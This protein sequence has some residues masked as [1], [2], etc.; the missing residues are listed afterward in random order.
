MVLKMMRTW[1]LVAFLAV[2][3][4]RGE[5]AREGGDRDPRGD[6]RA[7]IVSPQSILLAVGSSVSLATYVVGT[8]GRT[9]SGRSVTWASTDTSIASVDG[10]GTVRGLAV[11]EGVRVIATSEGHAGHAVVRVAPL[12]RDT[13]VASIKIAPP[14]ATLILGSAGQLAARAFNAQGFEIPGKQPRWTS[15]DS[16]AA[17]IDDRGLVRAVKVGGPVAITVTIDGASSSAS[18]IIVPRPSG[19]SIVVDAS[20]T[21]QVMTGWES[22]SGLGQQDCDTVGYRRYSE[23]VFDRAVHEVGINRLRLPLRS[24]M[25]NPVDYFDQF[26]AGR[27]T[28]DQWKP[29]WFRPV[30]DDADPQQLNPGGMQW[31]WFDSNVDDV[32]LPLQKR[33]RSR[34]ESL[35]VNLAYTD[36]PGPGAT[37]LHRD[38][39][40][41]YAEIVLATFQHLRQ[42]YGLTPDSFELMIEPDGAQWTAQQIGASAVAVQRR[43]AKH[44]FRPQYV[45]PSGKNPA[46][47]MEYFDAMMRVPGAGSVLQ[48]VSYHRY[49]IEPGTLS[50]LAKGAEARGMRTAMLEHIGS[51]YEDLHEDLIVGNASAWQQFGM[52]GCG[53]RDVGATYFPVYGA[54]VGQTNPVVTTGSRTRFLREYFLYVRL[55]AVR[56]RATTGNADFSPVAFRNVDGKHVV[57]VKATR[58]GRFIIR[59]LA[60]GT[61]GI[62]YTTANEYAKWL[63]DIVVTAG[64][65]ATAEIPLA[66]A[67]VI[68][69]R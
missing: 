35:W 49:G 7:V 2:L 23:Q 12:A 28:Y 3:G 63:P 45:G 6:G 26:Q 33:L 43:L 61:Y 42:K 40:E 4:C 9:E 25:E 10:S 68:H 55:G 8:D 38:A 32:L 22:L 1:P 14:L 17:R 39:P 18:I 59:G 62:E 66:G 58:G 67:I 27:L 44:G 34:G 54:A 69:A 36:F 21:Y 51:G 37:R 48:E 47:T 60:P 19:A 41:E 29:T 52:A 53:N 16:T 11:G 56:I 30:N 50:A 46:S 20:R 64:G 65:T 15:V 31:S 57:V 13:V 5:S 24:G